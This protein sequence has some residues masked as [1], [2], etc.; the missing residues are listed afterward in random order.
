MTSQDSRLLV[1][2]FIDISTILTG[3]GKENKVAYFSKICEL[4]PKKG[5]STNQQI[6]AMIAYLSREVEELPD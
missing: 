4:M 3:I 5:M 2:V 6:K 1:S